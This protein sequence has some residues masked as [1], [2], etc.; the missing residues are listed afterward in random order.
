VTQDVKRRVSN[1]FVALDAAGVIAGY[2]TFA[3]QWDFAVRKTG[4]ATPWI[5]RL[6]ADYQVTATLVKE[7]SQLGQDDAVDAYRVAF[8]YAIFSH[9]LISSL[10]LPKLVLLRKDRLTVLDKGHTEGWSVEGPIRTLNARITHD[11]WKSTEQWLSSQ[12]NYMRREVRKPRTGRVRLQDWARLTLP[13]FPIVVFLYCLFVKG[14]ILNGRAGIFYAL[15]RMVAEA[16][17][18]L[19]VLEDKLRE[20]SGSRSKLD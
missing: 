5:L 12:G 19:V 10:Y 7:I 15:Q 16:V 11:D 2:Y 8:D 13:G 20:Q 9:K 3:N 18:S 4:I 6:D 1:C 17:F 14:L